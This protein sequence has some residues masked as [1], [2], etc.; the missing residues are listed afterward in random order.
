M[1]HRFGYPNGELSEMI[2]KGFP[3]DFR[4]RAID[5]GASDG[6][7]VNSTYLLE[8]LYGWTVLSVEA[9]PSYTS[10]LQANRALV[11]MCACGSNPQTSSPFHVHLDNPEA[12]SALER[13]KHPMTKPKHDSKWGVIK[14]PVRT[15]NQLLAKWEFGRLDALCVD[16][17]GTEIDVLKGFDVE[18]WNPMVIVV[19]SWDKD[20]PTQEYVRN[21]GYTQV[22]TL[23]QNYVFSRRVR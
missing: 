11:E 17:E 5:V 6:V 2:R 16:T 23:V 21:L 4:G 14:V 18:R 12:F 1:R 7:T 20:G 13:V 8:K 10:Y 3:P 15:V 22:D 19:E 9:N